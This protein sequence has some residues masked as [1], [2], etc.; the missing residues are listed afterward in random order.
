M[1]NNSSVELLKDNEIIDLF[2][3]GLSIDML[4]EAYKKSSGEKIGKIKAK[5]TIMEIIYKSQIKGKK[6]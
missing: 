4:S 6:I 3:K 1:N 5:R 2:N